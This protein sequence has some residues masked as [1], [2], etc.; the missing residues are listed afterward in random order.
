[1]NV[2]QYFVES[3]WGGS[4]DSPSIK[5]MEELIAELA[6]ADEE[7]PDTWLTHSP[8][9]WSIRLDEGRIAYLEDS[10]CNII[11]H[12]KAVRP[13]LALQL[14]IRFSKDGRD[15][16]AE[17]LWVNGQPPVSPEELVARRIHG[18]K[19]MLANDRAFYD[20]LG[21]ERPSMPCKIEGCV[22]GAI[23][24]SVLCR[25]HHFEQIRHRQCPFDD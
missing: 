17:E 16:V 8:S 2:A 25:P 22:R 5:R 13:D 7:H 12:M 6:I 11:S 18:E 19:L 3:R 10:D 15:A 14:W 21:P 24:Y 23:E 20:E 1:M 4:E 9:G